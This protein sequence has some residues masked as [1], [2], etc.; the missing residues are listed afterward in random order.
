M[1]KGIGLVFRSSRFGGWISV[2]HERYYKEEWMEV[3]WRL[4]T[5]EAII[6]NKEEKFT[7]SSMQRNGPIGC[8]SEDVLILLSKRVQ[9][10]QFIC[11]RWSELSIYRTELMKYKPTT[12]CIFFLDTN[13]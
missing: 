11:S 7:G 1:T 5:E 13:H 10:W 8:D 6:A 4:Y 9:L 3:H 2:R 12:D